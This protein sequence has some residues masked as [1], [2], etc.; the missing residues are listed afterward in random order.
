M[1]STNKRG[2][3]LIPREDALRILFPMLERPVARSFVT[4][5]KL[6]VSCPLETSDI[7]KSDQE[8][9]KY[10]TTSIEIWEIGESFKW[11]FTATRT[12]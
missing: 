11:S 12:G 4:L 7:K 9:M 5:M 2:P 10:G 6:M 3:I 8:K 1:G